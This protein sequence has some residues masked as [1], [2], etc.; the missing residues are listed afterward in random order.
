MAEV[1]SFQLDHTIVKAPYVRAAGVEHDEKGTT[2]QKY[3][4]RFLQPNEDT[5]PTAAVHTLEHLLAMY[6]RD[7]IKGIKDH[8]LFSAQEYVKIV[9]E[10]GISRDPSKL[11]TGPCLS[12]DTYTS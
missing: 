11:E 10:A 3:D 5:L 4:L 2:V 1:E 7:E 12:L 8:S 9:L 6:L